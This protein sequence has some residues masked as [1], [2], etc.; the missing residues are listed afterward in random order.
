MALIYFKHQCTWI[1][2][3]KN[4]KLTESKISIKTI[5]LYNLHSLNV[6]S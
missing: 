4:A 2:F 1:I 6:N 3:I 5:A